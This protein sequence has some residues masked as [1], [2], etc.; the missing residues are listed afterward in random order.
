MSEQPD[1]RRETSPIEEGTGAM[2]GN[3]P[4]DTELLDLLE[5]EEVEMS[6][7]ISNPHLPDN[8]MI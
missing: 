8:P 3:Q 7:V 5:A 2:T 6:I 1:W 4:S